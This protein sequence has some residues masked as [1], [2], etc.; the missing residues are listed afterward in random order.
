MTGSAAFGP[1]NQLMMVPGGGRGS[2]FREFQSLA[3]G[4]SH[5][6]WVLREKHKGRKGENA[7]Y[8]LKIKQY[9]E[10]G[11]QELSV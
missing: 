1:L 9:L 5:E 11:N 3:P 7:E 2:L 6:L 4:I 10:E 8:S